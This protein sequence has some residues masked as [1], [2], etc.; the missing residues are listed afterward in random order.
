MR[1]P[2][3]IL[4]QRSMIGKSGKRALRTGVIAA[5]G[6]LVPIRSQTSTGKGG[7]DQSASDR[8]PFV[9]RRGRPTASQMAAIDE[10][11]LEAAKATFLTIGYANASMEAIAASAGISKGTLYARYSRKEDLFDA[12][13][14]KRLA[15]WREQ[16][17]DDESG[18]PFEGVSG[19]LLRIG[20][21]FLRRLRQP[22]VSAFHHLISAEARQFPELATRFYSVGF[23]GAVER[24]AQ[25]IVEESSG[26]NWPI[27]DARS[28]SQAFLSA[29]IGWFDS[30]SL[31]RPLEEDDCYVF[32]SRLVAIFVGGRASW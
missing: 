15:T 30:E 32:V 7:N 14:S 2:A 19:K 29:L 13:V 27:T 25:A 16:Q 28:I 10:T 3:E 22:E 1:D 5:E 21:A 23:H 12:V 20:T 6:V 17:P 9:A 4:L 31:R 24:I 26:S 11:I 18:R 8:P